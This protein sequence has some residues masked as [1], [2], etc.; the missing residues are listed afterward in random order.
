[1]TK[2]LHVA[3]ARVRLDRASHDTNALSGNPRLSGNLRP[4]SPQRE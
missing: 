2:A 3:A 4:R 1:M